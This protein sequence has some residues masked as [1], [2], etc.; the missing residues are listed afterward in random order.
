MSVETTNQWCDYCQ[1]WVR[2]ER[3]AFNNVLHLLLTLF[4]CGL[5]LPIWGLCAIIPR[6]YNCSRCG[7]MTRKG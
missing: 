6:H 5:W 1:R 3:P 7:C 4:C 2:A